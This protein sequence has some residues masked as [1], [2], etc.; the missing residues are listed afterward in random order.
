[1]KLS[2]GLT[3]F[4]T[5][6][7]IAFLGCS[8]PP[9]QPFCGDGVCQPPQENEYNCSINNGGDCPPNNQLG[10]CKDGTKGNKCSDNQPLFCDK[11]NLVNNCKKCGC[12][13]SNYNCLADNSCKKID[14][15]EPKYDCTYCEGFC[16]SKDPNRG[17]FC[18]AD[19]YYEW[20]K[21]PDAIWGRACVTQ[22][23][24]GPGLEYNCIDNTCIKDYMMD[25]SSFFGVQLKLDYPQY[26]KINS[27]FPL[28]ITNHQKH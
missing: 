9:N 28:K 8:S 22:S 25:F 17:S 14:F 10:I 4:A 6:L 13:N 1:M 3:I 26:V 7:I 20:D 18:G 2:L 11:G 5:L 19:K 24:C 16:F 12:F 27:E 23:D 21:Y 15:S